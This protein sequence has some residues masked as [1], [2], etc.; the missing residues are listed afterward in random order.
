VESPQSELLSIVRLAKICFEEQ[1]LESHFNRVCVCV[2]L[3]FETEFSNFCFQMLIQAIHTC[4]IKFPEIAG[5]VVNVLMD[6]VGDSSAA[7]AAD[8]V[9]FARS[10]PCLN[11]FSL[12]FFCFF[13][14]K[15]K[16]KYEFKF[17]FGVN[18]Q[19]VRGVVPDLAQCCD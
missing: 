14:Q 6:F 9:L 5:N 15:Q 7:S 16:K 19:R 8:V 18:H 13:Q 11:F 3:R 12:G 2:C 17:V 1:C 4:A 10:V